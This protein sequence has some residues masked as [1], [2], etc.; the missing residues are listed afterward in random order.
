M[1]VEIFVDNELYAARKMALIP[2]EGDLIQLGTDLY[3]I[4]I[5]AWC[6]PDDFNR[7]KLFATKH[8]D[9]VITRDRLCR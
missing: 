2:R 6:D 4:E 7:V 3:K 1:I 8:N 5:V 9:H